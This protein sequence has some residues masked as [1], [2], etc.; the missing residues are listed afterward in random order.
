M[1]GFMAIAVVM[2]V[3]AEQAGI[4]VPDLMTL[5]VVFCVSPEQVSLAVASLMA[6]AVIVRIAAKQIGFAASFVP[7]E[8]NLLSPKAMCS[9][10]EIRN[11]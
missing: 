11:D 10:A 3:A 7:H 5:A 8:E 6:F 2:I 4:A 9:L 1:T